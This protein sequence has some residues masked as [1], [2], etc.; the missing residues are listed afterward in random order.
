LVT[1]IRASTFPKHAALNFFS[2]SPVDPE[3]A[4]AEVYA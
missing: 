2:Y 3:P 1:S 4:A